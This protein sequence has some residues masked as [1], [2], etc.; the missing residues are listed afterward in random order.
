MDSFPQAKQDTYIESD[1]AP[2]I[3]MT[4]IL[5]IQKKYTAYTNAAGIKTARSQLIIL[6]RLCRKAIHG[7]ETKH[8]YLSNDGMER[9]PV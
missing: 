9:L 2:H 7:C 4:L 6:S 1:I 5:K 8:V 3:K